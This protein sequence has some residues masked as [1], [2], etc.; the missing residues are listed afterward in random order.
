MEKDQLKK[1]VAEVAKTAGLDNSGRSAFA[2]LIMKIIEP[3]HLSLDIFSSFMP[4]VQRQPG[5]QLGRRVTRSRYPIQ[6]MAPGGG[7]LAHVVAYQDQINQVFDRIITGARYNLWEIRS[8]EIGTVEKIRTDIRADLFDEIVSRVF[9]LLTSVWT[10]T[11]T[12]NNYTDASSGGVTATVLDAMIENI[13]STSPSVRAIVGTRKALYPV[14]KFAGYREY[15]NTGS[16]P[17]YSM[18]PTT[19]LQEFMNTGKVSTYQGVPLVELPQVFTNR[20][21]GLRDKLI[22]TD[23]ILVVGENVGEVQLMGPSEYQE[24]TD[25]S[26]QPGNYTVHVWQAFG[27]VID[28][29]EGIGVIKGNT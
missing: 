20:F 12:P 2:E 24:Q 6:T 14:Y 5:D 17:D 18:F 7:H 19:A 13:L 4:V 25:L 21:P 29:A 28:N 1:A 16:T 15:A 22:P 10:A 11:N 9:N 8:G 26:T 3:N 23:K 27:M